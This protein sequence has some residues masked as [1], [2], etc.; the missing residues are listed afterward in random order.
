MRYSD[1][2]VHFGALEFKNILR[3]ATGDAHLV[4]P[5]ADASFGIKHQSHRAG[6]H[7]E[8]SVHAEIEFI[9]YARFLVTEITVLSRTVLGGLRSFYK[10]NAD[11]S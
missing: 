10:G 7:I 6:D 9:T 4:G 11:I 1:A 8:L 3:L 5:R 2:L